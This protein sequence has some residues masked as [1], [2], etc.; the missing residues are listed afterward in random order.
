MAV[1]VTQEFPASLSAGGPAASRGDFAAQIWLITRLKFR[2]LLQSI[3]GLRHES[4]LKLFVVTTCGILLWLFLY[5]IFH[6]GFTFVVDEFEDEF[7]TALEE[8]VSGLMMARLM[9]LLFLALFFMLIFSNLLVSL[10]TLF[11]SDEVKFLFTTPMETRALYTVRIAEGIAFSSTAFF[12]LGSP[13]LIS[14]GVVNEVPWHFYLFSIIVYLPFAVTAA[15]IG[16]S[17]IVILARI[18]PRLSRKLLVVLAIL[19]LTFF[20]T[21]LKTTVSIRGL[22][23]VGSV[24]KVVDILHGTQS[25]LLPSY[26][27]ARALLD[28]AS[29]DLKGATYFLGLLTTNAIILY[30]LSLLLVTVLYYRSWVTLYGEG[31]VRRRSGKGILHRLDTLLRFLPDSKR[32]LMMKDIRLFWRDATQVSQFVIFFGLMALYIA[33]L[34]NAPHYIYLERPLWRNS[35]AFLNL[36]A[37]S[38]ILATLTTRFIFPLLSLEGKRFWVLGLAPISRRE[39]LLQKFWLSV[40]TTGVFTVGLTFLSAHILRVGPVVTTA[41]VLTMVLMNFSLAGLSVGLGAIYPN[42]RE[43]IPAKIVSGIGGTLNFV[44][45]IAYIVLSIGVLWGSIQYQIVHHGN[46]VWNGFLLWAMAT[47]ILFSVVAT[48]LPLWL[49]TRALARTE[50]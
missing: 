31:R 3:R 39:L 13:L 29:G 48:F 30:G 50:F 2:I 9:S 36:S 37:I 16:A 32:A 5:F 33:S 46:P 22:A 40:A 8:S 7:V 24:T 12:V 6:R 49:G 17:L 38:L 27:A 1:S 14:F 21:H 26:W 19:A 34:R 42:F 35:V 43:D 44:F 28:S 25:P 23:G 11:R 15:V 45:S 20:F 10:S 18:F 47:V 41:A 4:K